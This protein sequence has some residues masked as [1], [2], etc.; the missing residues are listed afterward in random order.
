[1]RLCLAP[2]AGHQGHHIRAA[3]LQGLNVLGVKHLC[4]NPCP[5]VTLFVGT[6]DAI[7][8]RL[9][10]FLQSNLRAWARRRGVAKKAHQAGCKF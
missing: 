10:D 6:I 9:P 5:L 4:Q 8:H 1:M 2:Q 7:K 3:V